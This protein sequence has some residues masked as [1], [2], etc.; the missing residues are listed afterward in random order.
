MFEEMTNAPVLSGKATFNSQYF[1]KWTNAN[2]MKIFGRAATASSIID[3]YTKPNLVPL[4]EIW[5]PAD[6]GLVLT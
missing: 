3:T 4:K 5:F 2:P 1:W 6:L